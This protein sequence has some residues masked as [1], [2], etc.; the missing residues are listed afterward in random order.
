MAAM[1]STLLLASLVAVPAASAMF[2]PAPRPA[3]TLAGHEVLLLGTFNNWDHWTGHLIGDIE[4]TIDIYEVTDANYFVG[5][6]MHYFE[7]FT[8]VTSDGTISGTDSGTWSM[9]DFTFAL[10]GTV[11]AGTGCYTHM[12]GYSLSAAGYTNDANVHDPVVGIAAW[13]LAQ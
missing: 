3:E 5:T 12:V 4:G 9:A 13:T 10:E 1:M 11:T 7:T 2:L 8:I 6:T